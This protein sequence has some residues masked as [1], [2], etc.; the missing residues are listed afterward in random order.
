[1]TLQ[2]QPPGSK[3]QV[4]AQPM[5]NMTRRKPELPLATFFVVKEIHFKTLCR[6]WGT[7]RFEGHQVILAPDPNAG[8][9]GRYSVIHIES[10]TGQASML[11]RELPLDHAQ[12]ITSD[13][14]R[15]LGENYDGSEAFVTGFSGRRK[16]YERGS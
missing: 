7:A 6:D 11:G 10:S 12:Q 16:L 3:R 1:M 14:L 13:F 8:R 4:G 9:N 5:K 2:A 15:D